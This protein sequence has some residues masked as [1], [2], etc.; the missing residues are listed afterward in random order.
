M[1]KYL[2][3]ANSGFSAWRASQNATQKKSPLGGFLWWMIIFLAVWWVIS[4]WFGGNNK[5]DAV[6]PAQIATVDV[7]NV[8]ATEIKSD[9][10]TMTVR[11]LRISDVRLNKYATSSDDPSPV[12]L[13]GGDN[14]WA[15]VGYIA[16]T[17][18][19]PTA[20][21]VWKKSGDNTFTWHDAGVEYTRTIN[22]DGY[23]ISVADAIK[24]NSKSAIQIA[25][26]SR[27][28]RG[29]SAQSSAAV[30][31]GGVVYTGRGADY[32]PWRRLDKK[33][34][35][36]TANMGFVGFAE[37]YWET[38]VA[39][40]ASDQTMR[41]RSVSDGYDADVASAPI[42]I[43]P[44]ANA[45][46]T[47]HIY[48]GPRAMRDLTAASAYIPGINRT[49]DYGWFWFLAQPMSWL[50]NTLDAV[51]HNYGIAIIIMTILLRLI[52]WPLTR[53]SFTSMLAMQ[54]MQP[55]MA[56]IQKQFAND[57]MRLQ[58]EM[59]KL[60]KTHKTSPMSGCL[61]LLIQ[62][63][64]FFALYKALLVSVQ[65]RGSHFL[66][67]N[68]L[69]AMDPYFILPILMGATMWLQQ[70]LQSSATRKNGAPKNDMAAATN[71][72]MKWMP[73]LFTIM[74]AWMP[75]GLVL[76]WTVSNLFGILQMYIIRKRG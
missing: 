9:D 35:A 31:V 64:I 15:E 17:G 61:P 60:Y 12:V 54:R 43:A 49:M 45:D 5:T 37:Q 70:Y 47:T 38:I 24:N 72:V 75:A 30:D 11:G 26:Y 52:L 32:T 73:A 10:V 14:T 36:F 53:K 8:P 71:R 2:D 22:V 41:M 4:A 48:A 7:S 65:M 51:V 50:L 39:P 28:V 27:I 69:A 57:K 66:W 18:R 62:I 63:P 29:P 67:I 46:I 20:T 68:D 21:S 44:G 6:A 40:T 33:S 3:N 19:A 58:M 16:A 25:P 76:Y 55:E 74:F 59:M 23:V 34:F 56:R 42:S 13:L 1:V